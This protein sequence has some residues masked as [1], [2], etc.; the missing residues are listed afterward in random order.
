MQVQI[1]LSTLTIAQNNK[2]VVLKQGN[3]SN[4]QIKRSRW[5]TLRHTG[6]FS[7]A[8]VVTD[9]TLPANSPHCE[10]V[11]WSG[12]QII[13]CGSVRS[14]W[15]GYRVTD[16]TVECRR[17]CTRPSEYQWSARCAR[18][19]RLTTSINSRGWLTHVHTNTHTHTHTHTHTRICVLKY[20]SA[21]TANL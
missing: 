13:H 2:T 1:I 12:S 17:V 5:E 8:D 6:R 11:A 4:R 21:Y 16:K 7:A 20:K 15:S 14:W 9:K 18:R 3:T 19:H 10:R